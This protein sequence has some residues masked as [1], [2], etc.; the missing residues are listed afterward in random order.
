MIGL[1][2]VCNQIP[3]LVLSFLQ[4]LERV[5]VAVKSLDLRGGVDEVELVSLA[6]EGGQNLK[7]LPML[8]NEVGMERLQ[9]V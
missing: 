5:E 2:I 9:G 6:P 1:I 4:F 3:K 8:D 7:E